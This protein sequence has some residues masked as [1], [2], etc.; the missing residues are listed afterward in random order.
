MDNKSADERI[1][2]R[3]I[4]QRLLRKPEFGAVAGT[5]LVF[6]FFG[7]FADGSM[8]SLKGAITWGSVAAFFVV[9]AVGACLLMIAGEFDL[10]IGSMIG[11]SGM[12][13]ALLAVH[14]GLPI[15]L[16]VLIAFLIAM[17]VGALNGWIVVRTGLPSF[18]V[19]LAFLFILRGLTIAGS[20][21]F[22]NQTLVSGLREFTEKDWLAPIF[23]GEA[24]TGF[25][26]WLAE[27]GIA[28]TFPNGK[29]AVTGLPMVVIWAILLVV[30]GQ[31]VLTRTRYG[32]WIFASGGDANSARNSG[33]PV[34]RVKIQ[35]FMFTA[36]CAT[37]FATCQVME[38]GTADAQRGVL[39]E[40]EAIIAVVIGGTLLTGGYG[41]VVGAMFGAVIFAVVQ[42]GI[43]FTGWDS[44]W[45]RVFLGMMLLVAVIFNNYIR[46]SLLGSR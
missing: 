39:K 21:G 2:Q 25:F 6:I 24:F 42:Q 18:I 28:R 27:S 8:F 29:P 34:H 38:F 17:G 41:S 1:K 4:W 12:I 30:V 19:T 22:T 5:I 45:F 33:V 43:F 31:F 3:G 32:N 23:G 14:F 16:S 7:I 11:F 44:D 35:L 20:R 13:M 37:L 46:K 36:F 15:W 40:F 9:I 10:S 26:F